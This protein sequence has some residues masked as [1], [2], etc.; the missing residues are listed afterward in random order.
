MISIKDES[1]GA[2]DGQP[3]FIGLLANIESGKK[4]KLKTRMAPSAE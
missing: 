4:P 3:G 1:D 2:E